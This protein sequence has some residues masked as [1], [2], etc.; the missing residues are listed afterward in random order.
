MARASVKGEPSV[1]RRY[2]AALTALLVGLLGLVVGMSVWSY[3]HVRLQVEAEL[4]NRLLSI[5]S[6]VAQR[7]L[8]SPVDGVTSADSAMVYSALGE[9][10]RRIAD[11]SDLGSIEV[12]DTKKRHLVG[13]LGSTPFGTY[14]PLLGGQLEATA[15][16]AGIPSASPLYEAP[17][18]PGTFFKTGFVPIEDA[19]G[20]I[21]GLVAVEGG[22]GFFGILPS[23]RRIW[24]FTGVASLLIAG[25]LLILLVGVFRALERYERGM[26]GAAA[27]ATAGQLAAVVAHEI[28]NPLAIL[29]SRAERV[30]EELEAGGDPVEVAGLL[31]IVP[32]EVRRLDRILTNYLSLARIGDDTGRCA[33]VPV[34]EETLELVEKDLGRVGIEFQCTAESREHRARIDA[35]PLRQALMNLFLNAREAMPDGG[36]L[37]VSVGE[38]GRSIKIEVRDTGRGMERET[39][40]RLFEPFFTTRPRGSGLGL[41]VVD[42]VVRSS[43]GRV[44]V[45][46]EPDRGSCFTLWLPKDEKG[47]EHG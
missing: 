11:A 46:S 15:A 18:I 39:L 17:E 16:L 2:L 13:T 36:R 4:E 6:V 10:L 32:V 22:S 43:G 42:S 37:D 30:Q 40:R 33:V 45:E 27:L 28:R 25:V 5:G 44:A 34:V 21:L 3:R 14:D 19:E 8:A 26:R 9:E 7:L 1:R 31:D 38:E 47:V 29:Q 24:G 23:L 41:A 12:I 20:E 35:G